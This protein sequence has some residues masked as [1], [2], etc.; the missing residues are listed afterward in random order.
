LGLVLGNQRD[1]GNGKWTSPTQTARKIALS[2][3]LMPAR[4][5]P[6]DLRSGTDPLTWWS[7]LFRGRAACIVRSFGASG[8]IGALGNA[9]SID[10]QLL[11]SFLQ[12]VDWG[13]KYTPHL[14][15]MKP[16]AFLWR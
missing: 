15:A 9:L 4:D 1:S 12:A 3:K 7:A 14:R 6:S 2:R 8:A 16:G 10:A 5:D 11:H 13:A